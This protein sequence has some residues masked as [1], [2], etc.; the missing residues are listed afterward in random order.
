VRRKCLIVAALLLSLLFA[1]G[2][3][4][5]AVAPPGEDLLG[6]TVA[7]IS[8]EGVDPE[9][10]GEIGGVVGEPLT[11]PLVHGLIEALW[12]TDRFRDVQVRAQAVADGVRLLVRLDE[13]RRIRSLDAEG[14]EHLDLREVR[15]VAGFVPDAEE[16]PDLLDEMRGRIEAAYAAHGYPNAV[17]SFRT[18][19]TGEPGRVVLVAEIREGEPIRIASVRITGPLEF[20]EPLLHSILDIDPG[21]PW[22]QP[23]LADAADRLARFY[24]SEDY[25]LATVAEP[26]ATP[27]DEN[28]VDVVVAVQ[29][30]RATRIVFGGNTQLASAELAGVAA[31]D[32]QSTFGET[33]LG[34]AADR[35]AAYYHVVGFPDATVT[36]DVVEGEP[37][38]LPPSTPF[39]DPAAW[40]AGQRTVDPFGDVG[41]DGQA[42]PPA[43]NRVWFLR[44][45]VREG[46]RLR[47][48]RIEW[49]GNDALDDETLDEMVFENVDAAI[50]R[51][52]LFVSPVYGELGRLG[53]SGEGWLGTPQAAPPFLPEWGPDRIYLELAYRDAAV[54][55]EERY[56]SEGYLDARV[57]MLA[58]AEDPATHTI[59][60]QFLVAEGVQ[61]ILDSIT[62]AGAAALDEEEVREAFLLEEGDPVNERLV[63]E[64][65]R[66]MLDLY[67]SNG[68]LFAQVER[69]IAFSED[70]TRVDLTFGVTEGPQVHVSAIEVTGNALTETSLVL[71]TLSFSVGDV[72][73][74]DT[75][76]E[77]ERR[78]L[79][80]GV[81]QGVTI[82]PVTPD[83]VEPDKIISVQVREY[84]PQS[85]EL[86]AGFSTAEGARA[87]LE[88][89]YR[90][91]FGYAIGFHLR[92]KLNYQLFFLGN[93]TFETAFRRLS[94]VDQLE[95]LLVASLNVPYLPGLGSRI[96]TQLDL[97]NE[98]DNEPFY[99]LDR[100]SA[101][102]GLS[103]GWRKLLSVSLR[104]GIEYNDVLRF[105]GDYPT[106]SSDVPVG[107]VCIRPEDARRLRTPQGTSTFGV[108]RTTFAVDWRDDPFNPTR[109]LYFTAS[110][111]W[112]RSVDPVFDASTGTSS[113]S[114]LIK[115][116]FLLS[117]YAPLGAG[118]VLAVSGRYGHV[119]Q[120]QD[121][122]R[123]FPDRYFY[124]GGSD[125]LRGFPQ[126]SL[127]VADAPTGFPSP[128]GN[129]FLVLRG[130]LRIPLGDMFGAAVFTDI[131]NLWR[132]I[133]NIDL[134]VLRYTAGLGVRI[135]TPIGPLAFDY[136]F[137]IL[138]RDDW[139]ESLG[140]LHFSIGTF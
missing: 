73:S 15:R 96:G 9:S 50:E 112:V 45:R 48:E 111:E 129:A 5:T 18:E 56:R 25:L 115:T 102:L 133:G 42:A 46:A 114:S 62:V 35:M 80:M 95:R 30:G 26:S 91:L 40:S 47:V 117:G 122:S 138:P 107:T 43:P 72:F 135:Q 94:L 98:R 71:G 12:A 128:G 83:V 134:S 53:L 68:Y 104:G 32:E 6:R 127:S 13:R 16:H 86:R 3:P 66:G 79:H 88:Y 63:E 89:G 125:T 17:V 67:A 124:L 120:L 27:R 23:G 140:A 75:A 37:T 54:R 36:W 22:D 70:R 21:D 136:G 116:S 14:N 90:N 60:P 29:P 49:E 85:L 58:P 106:C 33:E 123:T 31:F 101:F 87:S 81:F 1:S 64:T 130:E 121:A 57:S 39:E 74:P 8:V 126:E 28:R 103:T 51:S 110:G 119:F 84:P 44:F 20:P 132:D 61:S 131:G 108:L 113:F 118:L 19:E 69:Q 10:V 65:R 93:D 82:T 78:L 38:E 137:N 34:N 100:S 11:R 109:G 2:L 55:I 59:T 4:A 76:Q 7:E 105:E 97:A 99:G 24:R 92:L 52:S 41:R 139:G 77:S